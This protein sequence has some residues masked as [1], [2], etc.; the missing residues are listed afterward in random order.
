MLGVV[1]RNPIVQL[2]Q[3]ALDAA[4]VDGADGHAPFEGAEPR[5]FLEDVGARHDPVDTGH[6]ETAHEVVEEGVA[7]GDRERVAADGDHP[8]G[9]V[10]GREDQQIAVIAGEGAPSAIAQ[11]ALKRSRLEDPRLAQGAVVIA[12]QH[13]ESSLAIMSSTCSIVG[14]ASAQVSLVAT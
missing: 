1:R 14:I 5:E 11:C 6:G 2:P 3:R 7:V 8:A 4:S 9:G 13:Q 12:I 10:I